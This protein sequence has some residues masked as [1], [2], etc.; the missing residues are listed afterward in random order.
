MSDTPK[1]EQCCCGSNDPLPY[2]DR[3]PFGS[4]LSYYVRCPGCGREGASGKGAKTTQE[5]IES[6]NHDMRILRA[7]EERLD[8]FV[9]A[10]RE[11]DYFDRFTG[12]VTGPP[13]ADDVAEQAEAI[14]EQKD[15][16][17]AELE[18]ALARKSTDVESAEAALREA[19]KAFVADDRE[20]LA[21]ILTREGAR[22][23]AFALAL[24]HRKRVAELEAE[25]AQL[26]DA[27]KASL[28][29][30]TDGQRERIALKAE[31]EQKNERIA[32][33]EA[34][35]E[36]ARSGVLAYLDRP[37]CNPSSRKTA[38]RKLLWSIEE[39]P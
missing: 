34:K 25:V 9:G 19:V 8:G 3:S 30:I 32:E 26:R 2:V 12:E 7:V 22:S 29:A 16:R 5:A 20:R 17:I 24:E 1:I 14:I 10:K 35:F 11:R 21:E 18:A 31:I 36:R 15:E 13:S 39:R 37:G 4:P 28:E 27:D 33:L 6:W 23:K 38:I